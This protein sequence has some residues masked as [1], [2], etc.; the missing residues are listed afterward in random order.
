MTRPVR[1]ANC[2]GFYGDR[3][4]AAR[5]MIE[6]GDIDV[7]T[8]DYL[9][10]L[11][12]GILS[13]KKRQDPAQGYVSTFLK[14]IEPLLGQI[15]DRGIRVVSNAGGLNPEGLARALEARISE[16]ALSLEVAW[17][18]GD[19]LMPRL[20]RL[21]RE[22][23]PLCHMDT[24]QPLAEAGAPVVSANVYLGYREIQAALEA[25]ADI[26]ICPRV[27]DAALVMGPAAWWHGWSSTD[28]DPLAGALVAGHVIECGT[29]ATG[30]NYAFFRDIDRSRPIGFPIAEI[31]AGGDSIICKHPGTGGA[32]NMGTV[33]AQLLY[34]IDHPAYLNPD[35]IAHFDS[36]RIAA[37]D[38]DR[39]ALS[40]CRGSAPPAELKA[41]I[42]LFGGYRNQMDLLVPAPDVDL[43]VQ[44]LLDN[45]N[46]WLAAHPD[47]HSGHE[48]IPWAHDRAGQNE[49]A[50]S[51]LR[52]TARSGHAA[53]VGRRFS[54]AIVEQALACYPGFAALA[55]PGD[56]RP[57]VRYWPA[58]I[59]R[60]AVTAHWHFRG[61]CHSLPTSTGPFTPLPVPAEHWAIPEPPGHAQ[62][63]VPL[64]RCFGTRSGDKGGHANLGVWALSPAGF[65]FLYHRFGVNDLK[66]LCPD[67]ANY[68]IERYV[69][70]N[71]NAL[72]F[73]IRGLLG[74]GA[75]TSAR[76]DPQAKTL[77]EYVRSQYIDVPTALLEDA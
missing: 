72:N 69:L 40:G 60:S 31:D 38:N 18:D 68:D 36:L 41:C 27:T 47:I 73:V 67:L 4:S 55:P 49:T 34:E 59:A 63:S 48:L 12:M 75:A 14:Q 39:V 32:V 11:T 51:L 21:S 22:G 66:A 56:A 37:L 19:D 53:S 46:P 15:A 65:A 3:L 26:V 7:L 76:L 42:N 24:G 13:N 1:I 71:L 10:E 64:G 25:G 33:T 57:L 58:R 17:I 16:Q 28:L 6:G 61:A 52:L 30:G 70:P 35:V 74:E 2:S 8:G 23:H 54:A 77:G 44:W 20:D 43:K 9:A 5:E 62:Q 50:L 45:L 29:Q